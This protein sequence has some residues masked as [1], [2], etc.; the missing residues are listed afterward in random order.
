MANIAKIQKAL[1]PHI[2]KVDPSIRMPLNIY[3]VSLIP[4]SFRP[5]SLYPKNLPGPQSA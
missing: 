4:L 1:Y 2:P 3:K 5:I